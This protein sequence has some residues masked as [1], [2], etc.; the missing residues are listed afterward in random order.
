M[1]SWSKSLI[2][3]YLR[4][5]F[6]LSKKIEVINKNYE[7]KNHE[8]L[9]NEAFIKLLKNTYKNNRFYSKLYN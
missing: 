4:H 3:F 1:L 5:N 9:K 2:N 6:I 8:F 7:S